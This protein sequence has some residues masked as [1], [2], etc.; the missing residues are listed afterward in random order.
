M[1]NWLFILSGCLG[2]ALLWLVGFNVPWKALPP[3][4]QD[5]PSPAPSPAMMASAVPETLVQ[6]VI[7]DLATTA[8]IP[9]EQIKLRSAQPQTWPDGCL[10][11]AQPD[12]FCTQALVSGWHLV[13]EQGQKTWVYRTDQT[14]NNRRLESSSP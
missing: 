7:Q 5:L 8:K 6:T 9:L 3:K 10:G 2:L 11:L 13:L 12:E 14:G 4:V 1:R